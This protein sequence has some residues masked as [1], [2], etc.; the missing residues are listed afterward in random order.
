MQGITNAAPAGGG[1]KVIAEESGNLADSN[2]TTITFPAPAKVVFATLDTGY[3]SCDFAFVLSNGL[4][5]RSDDLVA[6]L[7]QDG[8][9]LRLENVGNEEK[10]YQY[11]ALG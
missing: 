6:I 4:E 3:R 8:R 5:A 1:L 7:T 9:Q 11:L 2:Q 10:N